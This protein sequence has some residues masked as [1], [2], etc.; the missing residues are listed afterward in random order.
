M[1]DAPTAEDG[2]AKPRA[3]PGGATAAETGPPARDPL[4]RSREHK[5][6]AGVCGG[7]GRYCDLDPVIFRVVLAVL[8]AAGGLGLVAYG[9][10]WLLIPWY[11]EEENE[12]RRLLSGRVEGPA[13]TAVLL[14]LVGCGLFL[15]MLNNGSIVAFAMM[16]SL[17]A[18]GAGY[19]SRHRRQ[20][21][22]DGAVDPATAQAVADAPPETRAPPAPGA[23]SWWR[24]PIVKDGTTGL[25]SITRTPTPIT[26]YLWGPDDTPYVHR[27]S[28]VTPPPAPRGEGIGGRTFLLAACAAII[29][30]STTW[31]AQPLGTS[32]EIGLACALAVFGLGLVVSS[33]YGRT[34]GGTM[35][36]VVLT[37][38]MLAG[39]AAL[40]KS[41]TADWRERTW[42]ATSASDLRDRY[43]L[44][45]GYAR[46]DL[47][48]LR[49]GRGRTLATHASV[50]A[51]KLKVT[52][53][54]DVTLRLDVAVGLG[55]I[56]LPGDPGSDVDV[57]PR[58]S[59][60]ATLH[61][62]AGGK[63]LPA[64]KT[65]GTLVLDLDVGVGQ[66]AVVRE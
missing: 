43:E 35:V 9:F 29:G 16:V 47:T 1:T 63:P 62:R 53:P 11:G 54:A 25:P 4:R 52:V 7:L 18:V 55:D 2:A 19:W 64:A 42:Q 60:E 39:A 15:S 26:T 44:G 13:L 40:P 48:A 51:G 57:A 37:A 38:A 23:P 32:L 27:G 21:E 61:P 28:S 33:L 56:Q 6:I 66:V 45:T 50:G 59:H 65:R 31:S 3:R 30:T 34:S 58:R 49:P 12:G 41:V 20:A 22:G 24:D 10:A 5:V 8:S 46:L 36:S 14:A 17:A